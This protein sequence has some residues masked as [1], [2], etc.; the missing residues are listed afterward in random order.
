MR[1]CVLYPFIK[2]P[3]SAALAAHRLEESIALADA[4]ELAVI[5]SAAVPL[6]AYSAG[7]LFAKGKLA[8]LSALIADQDIG[9]V[10]IDGALTPIQQRNLERLW[11]VKVIDRTGLI[12]EIFAKR[13]K[14]HEGV[15]QVELA[16]LTYQK[17]RLVRSWT[18]LERQRG[19]LQFVGGAG[20]SQIEADRRA[21]ANAIVRIKRRLNK[22]VK[23]RNLHRAARRSVPY[24]I[25]ALAGYTNAGK[26]TVFNALTG[27]GV[28][29]RDMLFATL[30]PTMRLMT[31]PSGR[32][33]ILSD[34]VGFISALPTELIAAFRST[35]EEITNADVILHIHDSA[36]ARADEQASEVRGILTELGVGVAPPAPE[37]VVQNG[38]ENGSGNGQVSDTSGEAGK[39]TPQI[40]VYNKIDLLDGEAL[41]ALQNKAERQ[42]GVLLSAA[43]GRGLEQLCAAI[44][45]ALFDDARDTMRQET[46]R[47]GFE[48]GKSRAWLFAQRVIVGE[49]QTKAGFKIDVCWSEGQARQFREIIS[50]N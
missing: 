5:H 10:V 38:W 49:K 12:L 46:L 39:S 34:T 2:S 14:S 24:R 36:S 43:D 17:S 15:L 44:D 25:V 41:G 21:L 37:E 33:V 22:I 19:G 6:R 45:A 16:Q 42:G 4:L 31:L 50:R 26:S 18:H 1:A 48:S 32:E 9:L 23:T 7:L 3:D 29:S 35:L 20:E 28:L 27:A 47:L 13:A 30:D 40:D 11:K 8:E